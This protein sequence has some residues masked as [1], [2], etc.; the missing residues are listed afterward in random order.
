MMAH[1]T[2]L[3]RIMGYS[4][5]GNARRENMN[6]APS[7]S[8]NQQFGGARPQ[9]ERQ[10]YQPQQQQY[11]TPPQ[12]S[13]SRSS[14]GSASRSSAPSAPM[15][16]NTVLQLACVLAHQ[17]QVLQWILISLHLVMLLAHQHQVLQWIRISHHG[18]EPVQIHQRI[19]VDSVDIDSRKK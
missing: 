13:G 9:S 5:F 17:H 10:T 18:F 4:S 11:S 6:T 3:S 1:G 2:L 16:S 8:Y 12:P 14:F 7:R 15:N 19:I